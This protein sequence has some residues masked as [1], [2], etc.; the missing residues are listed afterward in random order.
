[1]RIR[2]NYQ[3]TSLNIFSFAGGLLRLN[4]GA[5]LFSKGWT[6]KLG[7]SSNPIAGSPNALEESNLGT[8]GSLVRLDM[9]L[10]DMFIEAGREITLASE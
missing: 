1:M 5:P 9:L 7:L 10:G 6:L 3:I 2:G 8:G 4:D